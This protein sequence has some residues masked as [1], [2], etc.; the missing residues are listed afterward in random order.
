MAPGTKALVSIPC[1]LEPYVSPS[2]SSGHGLPSYGSRQPSCYGLLLCSPFSGGYIASAHPVTQMHWMPATWPPGSY[3]DRTSTG[4]PTMTSR[5]HQ[6][7]VRRLL[8]PAS[9]ALL[10]PALPR[11]CTVASAST[12]KIPTSV[13]D[14]VQ[15]P[16]AASRLEYSAWRSASTCSR[17]APVSQNSIARYRRGF[18]VSRSRV[19]PRKPGYRANSLLY[20]PPGPYAS[21][22]WPRASSLTTNSQTISTMLDRP[23]CQ[24]ASITQRSSGALRLSAERPACP[25]RGSAYEPRRCLS[26]CSIRSGCQNFP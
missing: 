14:S 24:P 15:S 6:R 11:G 16:K 4:K 21:S 20:A 23:L 19:V 1:R 12:L 7:V 13:L 3:H 10:R 8:R 17:W 26:S 9:S 2:A 5:T 25:A 18:F 22:N